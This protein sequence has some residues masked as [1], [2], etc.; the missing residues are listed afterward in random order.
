LV[1]FFFW[2]QRYSILLYLLVNRS[3]INSGCLSSF[4]TNRRD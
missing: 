2:V 3:G 4:N 1:N